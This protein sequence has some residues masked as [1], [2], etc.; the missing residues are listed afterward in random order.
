M[1]IV[2][3]ENVSKSFGDF[4]RE[5]KRSFGRNSVEIE[6]SGDVDLIKNSRFIERCNDFGQIAIVFFLTL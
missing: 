2:Q 6:Y 1:N 4:K 5:I 3:V